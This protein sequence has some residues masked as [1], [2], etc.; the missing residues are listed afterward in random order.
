MK[1]SWK[2]IELNLKNCSDK[3]K[4]E[5][6]KYWM[7]CVYSK[8][9]LNPFVAFTCFAFSFVFLLFYFF[10]QSFPFN[11]FISIFR[12]NPIT[13]QSIFFSSCFLLN[14]CLFHMEALSLYLYFTYFVKFFFLFLKCL[15]TGC[16]EREDIVIL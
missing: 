3:E 10:S 7:I 12:N 14:E 13:L 16:S 1:T 8:I 2:R 9:D 5:E 11:P 6:Q 15:L 4:N